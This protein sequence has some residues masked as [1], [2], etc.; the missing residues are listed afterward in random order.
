M[1]NHKKGTH[2]DPRKTVTEIQAILPDYRKHGITTQEAKFAAEYLT[3]GLNPREAYRNSIGRRG[4]TDKTCEK[5]AKSMLQ[6]PGVQQAIYL[7]GERWLAEKRKVF[8]R[9]IVGMLNTRA[10][11]DPALLI[12]TDGSPAFKTWEE[13]PEDLRRCIDGIE[14]RIIKVGAPAQPAV[15]ASPGQ[16]AQAAKPARA[17][18]VET[19]VK[20]ANR[21]EAVQMLAQYIHLSNGAA[22]NVNM[23]VAPETMALLA[24]IFQ[25]APNGGPKLPGIPT[26]RERAA[27][28]RSALKMQSNLVENPRGL[29]DGDGE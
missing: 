16:P 25:A 22:T 10:F 3:N 14:T 7:H 6:C 24:S 1:A 13:L 20:L 26:P 17:P 27:A 8:E 9:D 11:Y 19:K 5:K 12:N 4:E 21:M 29:A 28:R 23:A 18:V 15:A 2:P